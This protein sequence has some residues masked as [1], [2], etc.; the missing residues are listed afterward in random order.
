MPD[1]LSTLE[2]ASA[3]PIAVTQRCNRS[4]PEREV[5][6][7]E[8]L[9]SHVPHLG[10]ADRCRILARIVVDEATDKLLTPRRVVVRVQDE[11]VPHLVDPLRRRDGTIHGDNDQ[12]ELLGRFEQLLC[13]LGGAAIPLDE[14]SEHSGVLIRKCALKITNVHCQPS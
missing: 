6:V 10:A 9:H 12:Q 8:K 5:E 11:V 3:A 1:L 2:R 13:L 7:G 4:R 14:A